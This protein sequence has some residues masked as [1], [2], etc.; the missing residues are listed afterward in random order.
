MLKTCGIYGNRPNMFNV[1]KYRW[2]CFLLP[3]FLVT[4]VGCTGKAKPL[5]YHPKLTGPEKLGTTVGSLCELQ[6][7]AD[8]PVFGHGLVWGLPGTGSGQCPP[9][10]KSYMLQYLR[11]VRPQK[12]MGPKYANM[13]AEQLINSRDTA[14]V[15]VEGI[16]PA[17]APKGTRF[18]VRLFIPWATQTTSLQGGW[19]L[20]TDMR[21]VVTE[22]QTGMPLA[23]FTTARSAGPLF[24]NPFPLGVEPNKKL[25]KVD[26]RRAV[27]LGGGISLANRRISLA[28]L[29][30]DSLRAQQIQNRINARFQE[31]EVRK[32]ADA[33]REVVSITIPARYRNNYQHFIKVVLALYLQDNAVFQEMKLRQL[34]Q[35]A[36]KPG[37]DYE[38]I[39]LAWEAIGRNSIRYLEPLYSQGNNKLTFYAARTALNLGDMKA[40]DT[41]IR[42]SLDDTSPCQLLA[43][44]QLSRV[45]YDPRAQIA[46]VKLLKGNNM[47]LRLLA[48][49]GLLRAHNA[50]VT[51]IPLPGAFNLDIVNCS[52]E[53]M[54]CVWATKSPRVV[55]FGR[56][57]KC[58]GDIFY[59]ADNN[60]VTINARNTDK[61]LTIIRQTD[62]A[63]NFVTIKCNRN[64]AD[65]VAALAR[66][67]PMRNVP[68]W[69][70][71]KKQNPGADLTFSQISGILYQFCQQKFIPAQFRLHHRDSDLLQQ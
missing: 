40:I 53:N 37:A 25:Q 38:A 65:F 26:P 46:M 28:L 3:V 9:Y 39:A 63:G 62:N 32:V 48:Y 36:R 64:V 14:V 49:Q 13:T 47:L 61:Q 58:Q 19:L 67:L 20:P 71:K 52:G 5:A 54:I 69:K 17:G 57:V 30:P 6:G 29:Q 33:T 24:I 4:A 12:Y 55:V 11:T 15:R 27:V 45:P 51:S 44:Q 31:D 43:A 59:E 21:I 10:V 41:M 60:E 42:I 68:K 1:I 66:P 2:L 50:I 35:L 23:G 16:V 56:D 70:Q 18:D 22:A 7:Y 8:V 34:V